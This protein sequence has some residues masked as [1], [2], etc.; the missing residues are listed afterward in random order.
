MGWGGEEKEVQLGI[1]KMCCLADSGW[2]PSDWKDWMCQSYPR[3]DPFVHLMVATPLTWQSLLS[4][5]QC[6]F[7]LSCRKGCP[8]RERLFVP[9]CCPWTSWLRASLH[10]QCMWV[11]PGLNPFPPAARRDRE[12]TCR[13]D[14]ASLLFLCS[15][16]PPSKY[17][18]F[19]FQAR[20]NPSTSSRR[21]LRVVTRLQMS[22]FDCSGK[23]I[24][25][26]SP[27]TVQ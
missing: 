11:D 16:F 6:P 25:I 10:V 21:K 8:S 20:Q 3:E 17:F 5:P 19:D 18:T 2:L 26:L 14:L 1:F 13:S 4:L 24:T 9:F 12:G 7:G 27:C 15:F 22:S 23:D